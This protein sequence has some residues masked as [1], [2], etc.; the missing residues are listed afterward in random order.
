[1]KQGEPASSDVENQAADDLAN[2]IVDKIRSVNRPIVIGDFYA[3]RFGFGE[4]MRGL[5]E[6]LG[7]RYFGS[8]FSSILGMFREGDSDSCCYLF[9]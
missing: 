9:S 2:K 6:A 4:E 8:E 3:Q 5:C 7:I 1:L